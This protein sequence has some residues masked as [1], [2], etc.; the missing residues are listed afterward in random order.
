MWCGL[1]ISEFVN[2]RSSH[3]SL[4]LLLLSGLTAC[5]YDSGPS[6]RAEILATMDHQEACWNEG[7]I[8]C[9]MEGYWPSDSL[10]FIGKDGVTYGYQNTL[11]RYLNNYPDRSA[12]GMLNFEII[13]LQRLAEDAYFMVGKWQLKRKIGDI[14][15]HFT[16]L[17]RKIDG[18][19]LIVSDHSS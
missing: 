10:M 12:M 6:D 19:W 8:E 1:K 17:F 3:F 9:F 14:G 15:G 18:E 5:S 13:E 16:L 4:F 11:E 7:D 2:Y